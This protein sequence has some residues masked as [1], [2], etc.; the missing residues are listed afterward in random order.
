MAESSWLL[1]PTWRLVIS[2]V[3]VVSVCPLGL[4]VR[5]PLHEHTMGDFSIHLLKDTYIV[6]SFLFVCLLLAITYRVNIINIY[7]E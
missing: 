3:V 5:T 7:I 1:H 6:S 4:L 2:G